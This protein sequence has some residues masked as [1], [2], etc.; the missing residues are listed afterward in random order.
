MT[1][2]HVTN[3]DGAADLLK[4]STLA[5]DVLPWR[6]P[7]HHGPFPA[8]LDLEDLS[9]LRAKYLAPKDT[10][11]ATR[12]FQLR[13]AH[14]RAAGKYDRVVLWFEHDLLDQ[15]Q[16]LQLLDWFAC[17]DVG[18][19]K[20][21][22]ICIDRF[23]GIEPFRGLGQLDAT[24]MASL[25]DQ[26]KPVTRKQ[27]DL[28]RAGWSAFRAPGPND[29]LTF[30]GGDLTSLP[31]LRAALLRHLEE[32]PSSKTGLMRTE[33][34]IL[35]LVGDGISAP[36]RIFSANMDLETA[37]YIGDEKTFSH[38]ATLCN[39]D[40]QPLLSCLPREP[41]R[42]PPHDQLKPD[43]FRAQWLQ[44]TDLGRRVL[45]GPIDAFGLIKRDQW[46]GGVHLRSDLPIWTWDTARKALRLREP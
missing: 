23:N 35:K 19:T 1:N 20:L 4:A 41:F 33:W 10:S 2:L 32:Y 44:L 21:E 43:V 45:E 36:G 17:T 25:Y 11:D 40:G 15:L 46:L 16:L 38:I 7:M 12:D 39:G 26:R 29:L 37:L 18:D 42:Y 6:D 30:L 27:L 31:F 28:A 14:L 22:L 5:G 8:D 3:G 9:A 34:Q 24:Q 13:D